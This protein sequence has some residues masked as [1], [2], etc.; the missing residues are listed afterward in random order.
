[1]ITDLLVGQLDYN[2]SAEGSELPEKRGVFGN[3]KVYL[4][5]KM[6][7][8]FMEKYRNVVTQ[9][10][11]PIRIYLEKKY[12]NSEWDVLI[13]YK[14]KVINRDKEIP[15]GNQWWIQRV[16]M[17]VI[18]NLVQKIPTDKIKEIEQFYSQ[19]SA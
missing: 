18:I 5:G 1:M 16:E 19:Q 13:T 10:E 2:S 6:K 8:K 9:L 11:K 14:P 3:R 12:K 15:S 4:S 7:S 17:D